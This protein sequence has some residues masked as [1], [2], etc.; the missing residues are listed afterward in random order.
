MKEDIEEL[1]DEGEYTPEQLTPSTLAQTVRKSREM[2]ARGD[3]SE[4]EAQ[5]ITQAVT[6]QRLFEVYTQK[7]VTSKYIG[8]EETF[9][10]IAFRAQS[11]ALK[12]IST[13]AEL[14][15]PKKLTFIK[16]QNNAQFNLNQEKK[17]KQTSSGDL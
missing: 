16:Q 15:N 11:Q 14:K 9:G 12:T 2:I 6:L 1:E 8:A 7:M 13:L 3:F 10:Q 5:L 4:L 17:D